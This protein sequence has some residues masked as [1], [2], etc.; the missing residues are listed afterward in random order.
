MFYALLCLTLTLL[1]A[2]AL[3]YPGG[4][5]GFIILYRVSYYVAASV[6]SR[7]ENTTIDPMGK[8]CVTISNRSFFIS[9]EKNVHHLL[10][11]RLAENLAEKLGFTH[12]LAL[13]TPQVTIFK[14]S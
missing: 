8:L 4:P 2:W 10:L 11:D 12:G 14:F 5:L 9:V 3:M 13:I 6:R 1:L 7:S